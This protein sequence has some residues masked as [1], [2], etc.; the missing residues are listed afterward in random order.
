[1]AISKKYIFCLI[2]MKLCQNDYLKR[3]L[4]W[5]SF[6]RNWTKNVDFL[7]M[8][9]FWTWALFFTQT[10]CHFWLQLISFLDEKRRVSAPAPVSNILAYKPESSIEHL[11][12]R[13]RATNINPFTPTSLMQTLR[14]KARMASGESATER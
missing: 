12:K 7:L 2:L 14:K 11:R 13:K 6:M 8:A 4:F 9:N 3:W 10:L 5:R 1:M